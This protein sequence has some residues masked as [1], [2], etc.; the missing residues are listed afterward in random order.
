MSFLPVASDQIVVQILVFVMFFLLLC[1]TYLFRVGLIGVLSKYFKWVMF[2]TLT[3]LIL[4]CALGAMRLAHIGAES[5]SFAG[6]WNVSG[7]SFV[8]IVQKLFAT[9]YYVINIRT[10][11]QLGQ[12]KF[13]TKEPWVQMYREGNK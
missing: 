4:T 11:I 6:V 10:A 9:Y 7:Y 5:G 12:P 8:S 13:Y 2:V 3:Y 1:G